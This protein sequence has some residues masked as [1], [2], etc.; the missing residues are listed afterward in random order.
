MFKPILIGAVLL[1]P[2]AAFAQNCLHGPNET[3]G[4]R[5]RRDQAIQFARQVNAAEKFA[6][7][8]IGP[9]RRY[10]PLDELPNLPRVP[11]GFVLRL[12]TDGAGYTFSLKDSRD[13]CGFAVFSDQEGDVYASMPEPHQATVVPLGTR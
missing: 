9:Q 11:A 13:P 6:T 4:E 12:H 2:A 10:R 7:L 1:T 5:T 3:A 8:G